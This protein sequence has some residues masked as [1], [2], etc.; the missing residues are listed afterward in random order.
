MSSSPALPLP[1][2]TRWTRLAN[3]WADYR[4]SPVAVA[5]LIVVVVVVVCVYVGVCVCACVCV[6][7]NNTSWISYI[8]LGEE[9][10]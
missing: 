3:F 9:Y 1:T 6:C 7:V 4:Q 10:Y 5:A 8:A 2:E